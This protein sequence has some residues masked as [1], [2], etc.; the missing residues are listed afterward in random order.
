MSLGRRSVLSGV[1][2]A[3]VPGE[4]VAIA[5]PNGAG[6]STLMRALA[7]LRDPGAGNVMLGDR[8]LRALDR[9]EIGRHIAYVPQ[10]RVVHWPLSVE[11]IVALGRLPHRVTSAA[12]DSPRDRIAIENAIAT[13]ELAGI[14]HRPVTELSGGERARVLLARALA[15]EAPVLLAD[16]PTAGLDP[17]HVLR[18]FETLSGI[19][20]RDRAVV[21]VL[22][23]LS[24]ALR[25]CHRVLLLKDGATLAW[26]SATDVITE[27][28]LSRAY[29]IRAK[30]VCI[31]GVPAV[32][33]MAALTS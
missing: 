19:A 3:A 30:L 24:M 28:N 25:Y 26:G 16:E 13:M 6:K 10:D 18:L 7:G 22:H 15:Q 5:G 4:F 8:E 32:L 2:F 12:A 23:D 11:R 29:G 20:A 17:E 14:R 33:P 21:V 31:D 9:R 27:D 1:D